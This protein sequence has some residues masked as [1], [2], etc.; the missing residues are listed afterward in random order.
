M[1]EL[2]TIAEVAALLRVSEDTAVR[3]FENVPGVIDLSMGERRGKRRYRVLR[4][5]IAAVQKYLVKL[6]G[7]PV[8][9][10]LPARAERRRK[11][12]RWEQKAILNLAKAA[13]QNECTDRK[14]FARIA[15]NARALAA[16]VPESEWNEID[17][18]DDEDGHYKIVWH[19]DR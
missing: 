9:I 1:S 4:V 13:K 14:V 11:S 7:A 6:G 19:E 12:P 16:L 17:W 15:N 2:L 3:H 5:P 18:L 8:K 10:E